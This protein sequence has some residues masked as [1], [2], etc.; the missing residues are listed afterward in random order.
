VPAVAAVAAVVVQTAVYL[1]V[2]V[3][4][5]DIQAATA[6]V[7]QQQVAADPMVPAVVEVVP[8]LVH[9]VTVVQV[10]VHLVVTYSHNQAV[11]AQPLE[12]VA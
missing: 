8:V 9:Q 11:Q 3:H 5:A 12:N 4:M 2:P 7:T 10:D 1:V 6:D